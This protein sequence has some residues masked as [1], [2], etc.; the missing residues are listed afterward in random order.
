MLDRWLVE[1]ATE[2]ADPAATRAE[3]D[4]FLGPWNEHG[5]RLCS[6]FL[7]LAAG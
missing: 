5:R 4:A 3:T 1:G 6:A 7:D 2:L